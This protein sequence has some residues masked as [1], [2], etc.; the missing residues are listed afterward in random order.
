[1]HAKPK[2]NCLRIYY[3]GC[4]LG[5]SDKLQAKHLWKKRERHLSGFTSFRAVCLRLWIIQWEPSLEIELCS[6]WSAILEKN[7]SLSFAR[8]FGDRRLGRA[9]SGAASRSEAMGSIPTRD[10]PP[11][12]RGRIVSLS[13]VESGEKSFSFRFRTLKTFLKLILKSVGYFFHPNFFSEVR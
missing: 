13:K 11:W 3:I 4:K 8:A 9:V 2:F 10:I 1:M 5:I 12:L 6:D 7:K